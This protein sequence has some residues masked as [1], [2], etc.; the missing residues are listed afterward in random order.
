MRRSIDT[1]PKDGNA[2]ILEDDASGT[3]ELAHWCPEDAAWVDE[4]GKASR[5]SPTHWHSV[6]RDPFFLKEIASIE[7]SSPHA[8][9]SF[10]LVP[11]RGGPARPR[12]NPARA[13]AVPSP[14]NVV[15]IKSPTAVPAPPARRRF[16]G[17][18][19]AVALIAASLTGMYFRSE[20]KAYLAKHAGRDLSMLS[21]FSSR[22]FEQTR[23]SATPEAESVA[24]SARGAAK[25]DVTS[26]QTMQDAP[27]QLNA[28]N[29]L[30]PT[31]TSPSPEPD[32]GKTATL[33]Q[34]LAAARQQITTTEATYRQA[35]DEERAHG[36][37]LIRE[38][39]QA[40]RSAELQAGLRSKATD[41]TAE[42]KRAAETV[43]AELQ[44]ERARADV[45]A[46]DLATARRAVEAQAAQAAKESDETSRLRQRETTISE[47]QDSLQKERGRT[48]QQTSELAIARQ[49]IETQVALSRKASEEVTQLK[50][51][52]TATTELQ[53][54]LKQAR[55]KAEALA[56]ELTTARQDINSQSALASKMIDEAAQRK[57]AEAAAT[58]ELRQEREKVETLA[59]ALANARRDLET[60]AALLAKT[61]EE[62]AQLRQ[63]ATAA[64]ELQQ[65]LKQARGKAE[66]LAGELAKERADLK[67][68]AAL[69]NEKSDEAA[70]LKR[71]EATAAAGLQQERERAKTLAS[72]LAAA[73]REV[74]TQT[75]LARRMSEEAIQLEQVARTGAAEVR[76]ERDRV[77]ALTNELATVRQDS[78]TQLALSRKTNDAAIPINGAVGTARAELQ[79]MMQRDRDRGEKAV[80]KPARRLTS[81]RSTPD[82][83]VN[84]QPG[85]IAASATQQP[86]TA[87]EAKDTPETTRLLERAN[88]LL[89]QGN[90]GAA[91][92]VLERAA[93]TGS[94]QAAFRL[95]ETYDPV[96]LAS[97][98]TYGT[99]G[100]A[101]KARQLY[102]KAFNGGIKEAEERS[103]ALLRSPDGGDGRSDI[104]SSAIDAEKTARR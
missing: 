12:V 58:A 41:E 19:L 53:Q 89:N 39:E 97:W 57:R 43:T 85:Q 6:R 4:D 77:E 35:L 56:S 2:V 27:T 65:S 69:A 88:A 78:E 48:R 29:E 40:R 44:Q 104:K 24:S 38:L 96:V 95:A 36:I 64:A 15:P 3:F 25:S 22:L 1:V 37:A 9:L 50:R 31:A 63:S 93:E 90:I 76:Q 70:Q 67:S 101:A 92:V 14:A 23:Q 103:N 72:E 100:D 18:F 80:L 74:E 33:V 60:Q 98:G 7:P 34:E 32:L 79:P 30:L 52:T 42:L 86:L 5:I 102:A 54:A 16:A 47:L 99:R 87:T 26:P 62:A 45:L 83:P 82:S 55:E 20:S 71:A 75:T 13:L 21:V 66:E 59:S 81:A 91:R 10:P 51:G 94:A 68:K 84:N 8:D 73:R 17:S 49:E 11:D 28:Q 61:S 46:S